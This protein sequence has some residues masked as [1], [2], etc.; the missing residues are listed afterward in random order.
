[1]F[2]NTSSEIVGHQEFGMPHKLVDSGYQSLLK[3]TVNQIM[4]ILWFYFIK[5]YLFITKNSYQSCFFVKLSV[6]LFQ[7]LDFSLEEVDADVAQ[8]QRR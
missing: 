1:M 3:Q 5:V 7:I 4:T 2:K 6:L 8:L